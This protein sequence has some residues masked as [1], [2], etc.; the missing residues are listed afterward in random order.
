MV[1][2]TLNFTVIRMVWIRFGMPRLFRFLFVFL[3]SLRHI[4]FVDN[5]CW[6]IVSQMGWSGGNEGKILFWGSKI[7]YKTGR[8]PALLPAPHLRRRLF[9]R[10]GVL[11]PK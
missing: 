5:P 7:P 4:P 9:S 10:E 8:E 11:T 2:H 3:H 1:V 6:Q